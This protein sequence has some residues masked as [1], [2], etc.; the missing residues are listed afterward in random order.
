MPWKKGQSGNPGGRPRMPE[1]EELRKALVKAAREHDCTFL[2]HFVKRAYENDIV[3]IALAKKLIP[4][5]NIVEGDGIQTI[6]QNIIHYADAHSPS[7]S[8][9]VPTP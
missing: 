9:R 6:V 8:E 2:E 3:A 5:L 4:D 7:P 1:V